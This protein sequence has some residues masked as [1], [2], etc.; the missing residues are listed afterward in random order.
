MYQDITQRREAE[1]QL[2]EANET[3]E[4]RVEQRTRKSAQNLNDAREPN[5]ALTE[6]NCNRLNR[7]GANLSKTASVPPVTT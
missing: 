5:P 7:G 1:I 4:E 6:H 3:L 2:K